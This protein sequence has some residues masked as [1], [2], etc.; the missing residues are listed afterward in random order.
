MKVIFCTQYLGDAP[1]KPFQESLEATLPVIEQEGWEHSLICEVN[2]PYISAARA[3]SLKKAYREKP[4]AIV[5]LDYDVSWDPADMVKLLNT[6]G[7]VVAGT[8]RK[9]TYNV[10]YMGSLAVGQNGNP[11][12]RQDGCLKADKIPAGF[13]KLTTKAVDAFALAYPEL[14]FGPAMDPEL[15]IFNHGVIDHVWYGEDYAFSKR[16]NDKCGDIWLIPDL[17]INHHTRTEVFKGN[18]HKYLLNYNKPVPSVSFPL[19][20]VVIPLYNY[21][22]YIREAIDSVLAQTWPN[23][24]VIVVD[25]GSTDDPYPVIRDLAITSKIQYVYQE[26]QG[27][28]AARNKGIEI[29]TGEWIICLDADDMLKPTYIMECL[30][31]PEADIISTSMIYFGDENRVHTFSQKPVYSEFIYNNQ[32]HCASMFRKEVWEKVGGFDGKLGSV[33]DDWDFWIGATKLGYEVKTISKPLFLYRKHGPSMI[34]QALSRHEELYSYI[35]QKHNIG[36]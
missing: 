5:F 34:D 24:E 14:L 9:K 32:I 18:F 2:C 3:K 17:N 11:I 33:Y 31:V 23:V 26:N 30:Q 25:D 13:L 4:D 12:A 10:D 29:S 8:Y 36:D 19:V 27:A 22:K 20:S 6:D 21:A 35:K 16:W 7:D 1:L 15:D 28:A